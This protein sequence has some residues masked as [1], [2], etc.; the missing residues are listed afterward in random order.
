MYEYGTPARGTFYECR[1]IYLQNEWHIVH[2]PCYNRNSSHLLL[3]IRKLGIRT[4]IS[5][6]GDRF[7]SLSHL[8][9]RRQTRRSRTRRIRSSPQT[10]RWINT[11]THSCPCRHSYYR[12]SR[13]YKKPCT[14]L[15]QG[16]VFHTIPISRIL[17]P[18]C[19]G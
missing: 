1:F 14:V 3:R 15:V 2:P 9:H 10:R 16:F 18:A 4:R 19:A 13:L 12:D 8:S 7:L 5:L 11:P 17:F 6:S